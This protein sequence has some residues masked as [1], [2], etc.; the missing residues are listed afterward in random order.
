MA[1]ETKL[2]DLAGWN[3]RLKALRKDQK[4]V[5]PRFLLPFHFVTM[6][7]L[8]KEERAGNLR[9][10]GPMEDYA[11]RL[12]LWEA[13]GLAGP[14]VVPG[15]PTGSRYH[16]ITPLTCLQTVDS[17]ASGIAAML[18]HDDTRG[19]NELRNDVFTMLLELLSNCYH[20]ARADDGLHGLACAQTWYND[21][22]AQFAIA[23]SG[24]GIRESL[25]ESAE[26]RPRLR[27]E[28][29]CSLACELGVSSKLG[30]GHAGYGLAIAKDLAMQTPNSMLFV[31]SCNEAMLIEN[32]KVTEISTFDHALPGTLVVFEWDLNKPLDL[33]NV[34]KQWPSDGDSDDKPDFF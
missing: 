23:D 12:G 27:K 11:A 17:S 28:N 30:R 7:L 9:L 10:S 3:K 21:T 25:N 5:A 32:R 29:A 34:Y 2:G 13:I 16:E 8:L 20:H 4:C 18:T 14:V 31:Q 1:R 15:R 26:L 19:S 22:R 6:A 33:A 24:I